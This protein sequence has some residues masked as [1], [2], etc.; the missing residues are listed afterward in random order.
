MYSRVLLNHTYILISKGASSY[1]KE[2]FTLTGIDMKQLIAILILSSIC[3]SDLH[4]EFIKVS[5][6]G[7][8]LPET[9]QSGTQ[10]QDWACTYDTRTR[11]IW[12]VK[13]QD[14]NLR[15]LNYTYSWFDSKVAADAQGDPSS[16][17]NCSEQGHCDTE[18]FAM[19]VN[20]Q[21][22][23]GA[24]NWRLPSLVELKS[25]IRC[26]G[27]PLPDDQNSCSGTVR[28]PTLDQS[29]SNKN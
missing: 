11:L 13:S 24:R 2:I 14:P 8:V 1:V 9:A 12:E 5:N 19:D 17:S 20:T 27:T 29:Y 6:I 23:C 18:K 10:P 26:N 7:L 22:L 4:A 28:A 16:S 15:N 3:L 21:S 25:L